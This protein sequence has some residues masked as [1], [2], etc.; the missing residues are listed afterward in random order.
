MKGS[1]KYYKYISCKTNAGWMLSNG[2]CIGD[3][4]NC[5]WGQFSYCGAASMENESQRLADG[6]VAYC[7]YEG[8]KYVYNTS[9]TSPINKYL[10]WTGECSNTATEPA[11]CR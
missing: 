4:K 3:Y 1:T 2:N 10:L 7:W 11:E 9:C 8:K 5:R 6:P